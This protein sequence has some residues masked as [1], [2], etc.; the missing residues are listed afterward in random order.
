MTTPSKW[1]QPRR[2]R[3]T[4]LL[5]LGFLCFCLWAPL[6]SAQKTNVNSASREELQELPG[7]GAKTAD[8][9]VTDREENG[10]F[11]S[12]E[13][14]ARVPGVSSGTVQK[15]FDLVHVG[16]RQN[17]GGVVI[18]EGEAIDASVVR[19]VLQKFQGEPGIREVQKAAV[20]YANANPDIIDSLRTRARVAAVAPEFRVYSRGEWDYGESI[21]L[22]PGA[23]TQ[24][25][26]DTDWGNRTYLQATWD[27]DRLIFNRD[28]LGIARE[29]VR[30]SNL[31]DR[32]LDQVTRRYF[33]RRRLQVDLELSPSTDL[34]D[35]V[36]KELRIQ[37]LTA[38]IDALTGGWFSKSLERL[39][40]EPY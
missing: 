5:G 11:T 6:A 28:E 13:D 16:G 22:E 26:Y 19:K 14:L 10:P 30:L 1:N 31:R 27:L 32:V 2:R 34:A 24:T 35:R 39:G 4:R 23:A 8:A 12:V 7:I 20:G 18:K 37:E 3:L 33:E 9:I 17:V 38:D 36:R 15:L 21:D 40:T 29:T 25:D